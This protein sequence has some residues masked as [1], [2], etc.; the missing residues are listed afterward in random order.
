MNHNPIVNSM[1]LRKLLFIFASTFLA[2]NLFQ[3]HTQAEEITLEEFRQIPVFHQGRIKPFDSY[4]KEMLEQVCNTTKGYVKLD[5]GLYFPAG[6]PSEDIDHLFPEPEVKWTATEIVLSWLTEPE[7]WEEVPFIYAAHNDVRE[8]IDVQVADLTFK[9]VSPAELMESESL[10]DWLADQGNADSPS[11][12]LIEKVLGRLDTFRGVSLQA[13]SPLTGSIQ[14]AD[15]GDRKNFCTSV[16]KIV[17]LL[18][19]VKPGE[20]KSLFDRLNDHA[21]SFS[22]QGAS[23]QELAQSINQSLAYSEL[24]QIKSAKILGFPLPDADYIQEVTTPEKMAVTEIAK[25]VRAYCYY[26]NQ[27]A[28]N[29]S[30]LLDELR[31]SQFGLS[32]S[33]LDQYQLEFREMSTKAHELYLLSLQLQEVL[34]ANRHTMLVIPSSNPYTLAKNRDEGK[35]AQPWLSLQ[36]VLHDALPSE[37]EV[38]K[39]GLL[40]PLKESRITRV[41]RSWDKL[42]DAYVQRN[43]SAFDTAQADFLESLQ[44]LGEEA[45][46]ARDAAI[47]KTLSSTNR[48]PDVMDY[49][50][51]PAGA[52]FQRV[53]AEIKYND[54]KPFQY[55]AVFSFL[56]LIAFALSF[57]TNSVKRIAFYSGV[58]TLMIGLLWTVYGFYLRVTITGWAPV[59]NMYETIIFVPFIVSLLAAWF[60]L[61]PVTLAGIKDSWRL[62]AAPFLKDIPFLNESRELSTSQQT[63]F[64]V[65]TWHVAGYISTAARLVLIYFL[66]YYLTQKPYGDGG[67]SYFELTPTDWSSLNRIG[68]W[69]V[70]L[71]CLILTLWIIPRFI[72]ATC[73]S[74]CLIV[75]DYFHRRVNQETSQKAFDEMHKRR[76]FGI[77]GTFM[78]GIGGLVLLLSNS[79]PADAQ[80]VSEN[81]SPLQPVLR[82]NFWLTIH[83]LTIVASYGAG[84][85]ALGLGTI[86]L[87]YYIFGKYRLPAGGVATGAHRPPEQCATLAQYCYRS[88][89]VAVLLLAVGTILGGLWA[90]VSWGRFWG[91]DPKEVWALISLLIYLAF[92][93][94]RFAGWLNNFGMIAGTIAGFSMIMMSWVGV[95]FGLPLLSDT[96]SV[97]LHSY[98]AGENASRAIGSVVLVVIINWAFLGVAWGRYKAGIAGIGK[99]MESTA[100]TATVEAP[101]TDLVEDSSTVEDSDDAAESA[102]TDN[103]DAAE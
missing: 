41:R 43:A 45:T 63:R 47:G 57:G 93:H 88:I 28:G 13:D 101:V 87:G 18:N 75:Q 6:N 52:A 62:T 64:T 60:L 91:W 34:Y 72:I 83:V 38:M 100:A 55:T 11:F 98:G 14:I 29:F 5:M 25:D 103:S 31:N 74:P 69:A 59:T 33:Q 51:Y 70:G 7:R 37:D 58:T 86:A 21:Q 36:A 96:G 92:L 90:D 27:L 32:K 4:A 76:F 35:N 78:T 15:V 48:D 56:A 30:S 65:Q 10:K 42:Q 12:K 50:A 66:F 26:T 94:A 84:G 80:I 20:Q 46:D 49:T 77:G 8:I 23:G 53:Q 16:R 19:E 17:D 89:Q 79:L 99:H 3:G 54:S 97:G 73:M 22:A 2:S 9:Y 82:S 1:V 40:A 71:V 67:R 68:V 81:F 61:T 85:L 95:N 24:M 44:T 102:E 39:I